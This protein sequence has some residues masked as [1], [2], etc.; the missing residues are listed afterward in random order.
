MMTGCS[1]IFFLALSIHFLPFFLPFR[2][3]DPFL[4]LIFFAFC[5]FWSTDG[6]G[7]FAGDRVE[8]EARRRTVAAAHKG[9]S[10]Q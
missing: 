8:A 1:F 7:V 6:G 3:G 10:K 4:S 2:V 5:L 9:A